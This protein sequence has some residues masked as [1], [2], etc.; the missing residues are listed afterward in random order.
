MTTPFILGMLRPRIY[1]PSGLS[2][3]NR[4]YVIAHEQSHLWWKDHWWKPLAFILL[5]V[6]WFDP[7]VWIAYTMV[8]S[9]IEFACDERV[10]RHYGLPEKKAYS[11]ALLECSDHR[12][13]VLVCPVAFGETAVVQRVRNVLNYKKPRL[14]CSLIM[15]KFI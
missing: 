4:E 12:K 15:W 11:E 3:T 7:L 9:D 5:A 10:V 2:E 8:C 14:L 1:L 6:Y 13:L